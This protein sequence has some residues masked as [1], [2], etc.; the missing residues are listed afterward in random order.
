MTS[1][2]TDLDKFNE[3]LYAIMVDEAEGEALARVKGC[4]PGQGVTAY[5]SVYKW[6]TVT[7]GFE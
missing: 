6:Y 4:I 3:D 1:H 2:G 7:G 5:M